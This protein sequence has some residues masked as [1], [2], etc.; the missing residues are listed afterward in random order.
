MAE[1]RDYYY[2]LSTNSESPEFFFCIQPERIRSSVGKM[3]NCLQTGVPVYYV[4]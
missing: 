1:D 3:E 2:Q 4:I